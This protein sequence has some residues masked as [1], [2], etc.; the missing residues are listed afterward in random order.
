LIN[1]A[2]LALVYSIPSLFGKFLGKIADKKRL[3]IYFVS[4]FFI[5]IILISLA[6]IRN[7]LV[8][9]GIMFI[10]SIIFELVSLTNKGMVARFAE[11]TH[12]GETDGSLNGISALGAII[13][14][15]L[16]GLLLD[17]TTQTQAYLLIIFIAVIGL[18]TSF[19]GIKIFKK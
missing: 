13:G 6:F 2:I 15:V 3:K 7:Y 4:F 18:L 17:L 1:A 9:L 11:R 10:S 8:L 14:P 12:L 16:F 19:I 5:I